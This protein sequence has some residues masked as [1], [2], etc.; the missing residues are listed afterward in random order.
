MRYYLLIFDRSFGFE[1]VKVVRATAA[2]EESGTWVFRE[3]DRVV[4]QVPTRYV[5]QC[6][7]YKTHLEATDAAA[8]FRA[9]RAGAATFHVDEAS[10]VKAEG[11][12]APAAF[13][14]RVGIVFSGDSK[15]EP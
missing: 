6:E 7:G 8:A 5:H 4:F 12:R 14:E 15:P 1:S 11:V 13:T 3:D 9:R 2:L 10:V